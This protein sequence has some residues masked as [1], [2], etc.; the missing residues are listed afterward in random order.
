M[1]EVVV[2]Q[3]NEVSS[4]NDETVI[5][6]IYDAL[7]SVDLT[8]YTEERKGLTYLSWSRAYDQAM[9]R[10]PGLEYKVWTF[11]DDKLPFQYD[12]ILGYM[13]H[14]EITIR[15]V[16]RDMWL[17]VLDSNNKAMKADSYTYDTKN[18]KGIKVEAA[19]FYDINK[20]I[21]RCL[22]KN[23][24][25][26]GLGIYIYNGDD[27][28]EASSEE[29]VDNGPSD[30]VRDLIQK[31]SETGSRMIANGAERDEVYAVVQKFSGDRNPANIRDEKIANSILEEMTRWLQNHTDKT[32]EDGNGKGTSPTSSS[33]TGKK[34]KGNK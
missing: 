11:G 7:S 21:M 31:I 17:P 4:C 13:V 22:T 6:D 34:S 25:M 10:Y 18:Q 14:T 23:L 28:P 33:S 26:F 30:I 19:T 16:T 32:H 24:A 2:P 15:G 27:L 9:R 12:P 5:K 8:G 29:F 1:G 20:A 3:G